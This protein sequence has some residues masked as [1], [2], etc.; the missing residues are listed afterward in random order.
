MK[1]W[2]K[3]IC[4]TRPLELQVIAPGLYMQRRNI[5][6]V[7]HEATSTT[8]AYTCFECESR[9]ISIAE[10]HQGIVDDT[11]EDHAAKLDYIAM[12]TD[13]DIEEV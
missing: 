6:E 8:P 1:D 9:E 12:M 5:V 7:T 10:Y 4:A 3:E 2:K 11:L 13:I